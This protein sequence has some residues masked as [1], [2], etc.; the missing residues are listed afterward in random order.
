M[1]DI[2]S[3]P[4][5]EGEEEVNK[6]ETISNNVSE[7]QKFEESN[8]TQQVEKSPEIAQETVTDNDESDNPIISD[9]NKDDEVLNEIEDSNAEDAEDE[10]NKDRHRI[11]VK[12]YDT[13]S[14]EALA[15][16]LEK[17]VKNE[18]VQAIKSHVDSINSEFKEKFQAL[19]DEKKEEFLND[20]GNEIDFYYA[21]PVQK[22][23]KE[24]Y[25]E[26]RKKLNEHYQN[27]EQNLK[28]NLT[29]KLEI[30]EELKGL[31]NVEENIN[32]TYKHFKELQERWRNTGPIP[33]D[34]YNNA[35]NSYH[36][37]VEMF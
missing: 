4:K 14:L 28:Q 35:W 26:Y 10:G 3:L 27:L 21:S 16:E 25:N 32:T 24:A 6:K 17:L 34:K 29:D 11:E 2:N 19:L 33:R 7:E 36:H 13:M 31:I 8:E 37:H 5:A 9:S 12:A 18:K 15:I 22:R 30:I 1:S 23:Y 20:G